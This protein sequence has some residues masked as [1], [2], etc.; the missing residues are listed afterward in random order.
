MATN[1][2]IIDVIVTTKN[3]TDFINQQCVSIL[4]GAR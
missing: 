3:L 4:T 1:P 2:N